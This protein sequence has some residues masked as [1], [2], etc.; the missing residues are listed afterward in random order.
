MVNLSFFTLILSFFLFSCSSGEK[1]E[2]K[3]NEIGALEDGLFLRESEEDD[4]V[5]LVI[6]EVEEYTEL[7]KV[8]DS[9]A[10]R[11]ISLL[12]SSD[13]GIEEVES[14]ERKIASI[15]EVDPNEQEEISTHGEFEKYIVQKDDSL[16]LVSFKLYNS[17]D[18]WIEIA[19]WNGITPEM[20]YKIL[21]GSTIKFKVTDSSGNSWIPEGSPYLVRYGDYLGKISKKVY[22]G[23][24][25][26]W[27]DWVIKY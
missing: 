1:I 7:R 24:A 19:K 25:R 15:G 18:R 23:N 4:V 16:M 13:V 5:E 2:K 22:K 17:F 21:E 3:S 8:A 10:I 14:I 26:F 20:G 27:Y 11:K 6:P 12:A 9:E